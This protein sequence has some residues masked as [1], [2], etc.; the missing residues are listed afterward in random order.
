[1][2]KFVFLLVALLIVPIYPS[3]TG[4]TNISKPMAERIII[5]KPVDFDSAS[6]LRSST[7]DAQNGIINALED[8]MQKNEVSDYRAFWIQNAIFAKGLPD[9]LDNFRS[10]PGVQAVIPNNKVYLPHTKRSRFETATEWNLD[11]VKASLA[12]SQTKGEGALIGVLDSGCDSTH[13]ELKD[14]IKSFAAFDNYGRKTSQTIATD[15][16]GHGTAVSSII[17]G[18]TVG[19]AP[20]AKLIVGSVIPYGG[21]SLSQILAGL[22]W[23]ADPDNDPE[24]KDYP[25]VV[26]MSFGA[27]GTSD[28]LLP[29]IKNLK[30]LGILPVSSIGNDGEGYT[31]NPGNLEEVFSVGSVDYKM[32]AS[33][34]SS[35]DNVLWEN[36]EDSFTLVK[37]DI[38]APGESVRV[39]G[40]H[41]TYD[42]MDGTS[43]ASPHVAGLCA[44][45]LSKNP[46]IAP[47]DLKSA[48]IKSSLDLGKPGKDKRFGNGLIDCVGSIEK[49]SVKQRSTIS[50]S[51]PPRAP[52]WGSI[53]LQSG[54]DAYDVSKIQAKSFTYMKS[55]GDAATLSA[56]G[57]NPK[58]VDASEVV[59]DPLTW[60]KVVFTVQSSGGGVPLD[61]TVRIKGSPLP[62]FSSPD[63]EITAFLPDG[64]YT[65]WATS[66]GHANKDFPVSVSG[67]MS[68]SVELQEAQ[69]AFIDDRKAVFGILP[70]PIRARL[71]RA[72]DNLKIPYFIWSTTSGRV[73]STQLQK[74]K[75]LFWLSGGA[76]SAKETGILAPY[77]DN[78]GKLILMSG[79]YGG[80]YFDT[81]DSTSFLQ[82]YFHCAPDYEGGTTITHHDGNSY[83]SLALGKFDGYISSTSLKPLSDKATPMFMFAGTNPRRYAGLAVS[84]I[85]SQG[86][87]LGFAINDI[88]SDEDRAWAAKTCVESFPESFSWGASV[89]TS[90]QKAVKGTVTLGD[91]SLEFEDSKIFIPHVLASGDTAAVS[92]FGYT[93][94]KVQLSKSNH[95]KNVTLNLAQKGEL[96]VSLNKPAF[97]LFEDVPV[98]PIAVK[99]RDS[100]S[101]PYGTYNVTIAS[102]GFLPQTLEVKVPGSINTT[103][104]STP[105]TVLV[106]DSSGKESSENQPFYEN[107][108]QIGMPTKRVDELTTKDIV[109]SGLL[110]WSAPSM[111]SLQD[112][113]MIDQVRYALGCDANII[114]SGPQ[115]CQKFDG[116]VK[117]DSN[118]ANIY[119][120]MGGSRLSNMLISYSKANDDYD[121]SLPVLGGG[122][123]LASY[124]GSGSSVVRYG[125]LIAT[126]F[127][128]DSIDLPMTK[129]EL[130]RR[131]CALLGFDL[132]KLSQPVIASPSAPT[133]QETIEI[134][135]F[136]PPGSQSYAV[137]ENQRHPITLDLEGFFVLKLKLAEG[138]YQCYIVSKLG[139]LTSASEPLEINVDRTPPAISVVCP[140]GGKTSATQLEVL[141]NIKGAKEVKVDGMLTTLSG[142]LLRKK[143]QAGTGIILISA[144]DFAGNKTN[145]IARYRPEP[146]YLADSPSSKASFEISQLGLSNAIPTEWNLFEPKKAVQ[147]KT[148]AVLLCKTLNLKET[149][150]KSA[151][152]DIKGIPEENC[153]HTLAA[154]KIISGQG[155]FE[156]EKPATKELLCQML[157][158]HFKLAQQ[159]DKMPF[160][161]ISSKDPNFKAVSMCLKAGLISSSD[162]RLFTLGKFGLGLLLSREQMAIILYN[163]LV[164]IAK[165]N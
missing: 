123:T 55:P 41:R 117:I 46:G 6:S 109:S 131:L 88:V 15:E 24:T 119:A 143:I 47:E 148:L 78:G 113:K 115:L 19:V 34:F 12:W 27:A 13:P 3:N 9:K 32:N 40:L 116:L 63:G 149:Q 44:L 160:S 74:Y 31:S 33:I 118:S 37:P 137:I 91:E 39:A 53:K 159:N 125:R 38:C 57:F 153:I 152:T 151:Y 18:S 133:N 75:T 82:S 124:L 139:N 45:L 51:W 110:I 85:K 92:S 43:F 68:M 7:Q 150:T 138:K 62:D 102:K 10:F 80:G 98:E 132:G 14:K 81:S 121:V 4:S 21:G 61:S 134:T 136:C 106:K 66:F 58:S 161:D 126:A 77:M 140:R 70:S 162:S 73:S 100:I 60:R 165:G 86:I 79:Y 26:N 127:S 112:T 64:N 90:N 147:R 97:I 99:E 2:R 22:Q 59:L 65:A 95:P 154:N 54:E 135:G 49:L 72:F 142:Q 83:K 48:I 11:M 17:A 20:E 114:I 67:D 155:K 35:G 16:D 94:T 1:M 128:F 76:L 104:I 130:I 8:L 129:T 156:P 158:N 30:N 93:D 36:D 42:V 5:L 87:I 23:I 144:V 29:G 84:S 28:L 25:L 56:F 52:L 122:E 71:R 163:T 69:I 50:I 111:L 107:L 103:L 141:A 101:L 108:S 96:A 157:A 120:S 145:H 164:N 105:L 89:L 146:S